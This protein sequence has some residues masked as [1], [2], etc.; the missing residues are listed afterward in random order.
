[1]KYKAAFEE[2]EKNEDYIADILQKIIRVNTTVPPGENYGKLVDIVEPEFGKFGFDTERV[3]VP[4]DKVKL[5]P[6]D[7]HGER[8]N[9]VAT[10]RNDKPKVSAY[11]HMDVVP[12]AALRLDAPGPGNVVAD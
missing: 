11:A 5:M 10:L 9:L 4:E 7:L 3:I 1:M 8:V 6:W 12:A 2:V